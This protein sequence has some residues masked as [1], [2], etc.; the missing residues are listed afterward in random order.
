VIATFVLAN[1]NLLT[2]YLVLGAG[3]AAAAAC[4]PL[5]QARNR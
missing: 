4:H 1:S 5:G 3:L 2:L